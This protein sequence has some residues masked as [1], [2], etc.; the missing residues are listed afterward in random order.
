[1]VTH[2]SGCQFIVVVVAI[3]LRVLPCSD[4][5]QQIPHTCAC[6]Y[7]CVRVCVYVCVCV[8]ECVCVCVRVCVRGCVWMYVVFLWFWFM[9]RS[10]M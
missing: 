7:V 3:V 6:L 2:E 5:R 1:M 4:G 9:F 10:C 8:C